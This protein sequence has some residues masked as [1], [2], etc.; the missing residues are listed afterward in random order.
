MAEVLGLVASVIQVAGA[1]LQLSQTLYEYADGVANADR[2]I[3]DIAKEIR[4]TSLVIDE[5]GGIFR[6]DETAKLISKSAVTTADETLKECSAVFSEIDATLAKSKKGK[7]GRFMLPFR[8]NKIEL[9]RSHIDK[10]KSTLQLLMQVLVHAFQ[11]SSNKLDRDAEAR[12]RAELKELLELQKQSNQRYEDSLRNF[13]MSDT[14]TVIDDYGRDNDKNDFPNVN[15]MPLAIGSTVTPESLAHCVQH[16]Q[17]L[18]ESIQTLQQALTHAVAGDDH[19]DHHQA[20]LGSYLRTR[21]QLDIVLLGSSVSKHLEASGV[22]D[23]ASSKVPVRVFASTEVSY[24]PAEHTDTLSHIVRS[25]GNP[26]LQEETPYEAYVEFKDIQVES[27]KPVQPVHYSSSGHSP[28]S[29]SPPTAPEA[30][31]PGE[32]SKINPSG[33]SSEED[34]PHRK[35]KCTSVL[36]GACSAIR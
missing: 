32:P 15:A 21:E 5:L 8:E 13:S 26:I 19:S 25:N 1:G 16:V 2:K 11:V 29:P 36:S 18:L 14:S 7:M 12:Q 24:A 17:S 23:E 33:Q 6:Q 34:S 9:L 10:L 4:L 31:P 22:K 35:S 3:Q 20:L 27:V 28:P 30:A